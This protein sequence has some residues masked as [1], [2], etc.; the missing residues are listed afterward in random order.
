MRK[1][2]YMLAAAA[3][4]TGIMATACAPKNAAEAETVISTEEE[5]LESTESTDV[6]GD[7]AG[8]L[9]AVT[10]EK[11]TQIHDAVKEVYGDAY[12]PSMPYDAAALEEVFGVKPDLCDAFIAEGP[13]ISV[14]VETFIGIKAKEGKAAEI[15]K[16]LTGYRDSQIQSAVQYPMNM[17]KL[18][19]SQVIEK[20]DYVFF[21]MLG[22]ADESAEEVSEEA[23]LESAKA[24]NQKAV[25]VIDGFFKN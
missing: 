21:V 14:H 6:T 23:A 2:I 12:I 25:D 10:D 1:K 17:V 16:A 5:T 7:A 18:E 4:M 20:G 8:D 11:L 9:E 24:D 13:M 22:S 19:A 3:V 15:A